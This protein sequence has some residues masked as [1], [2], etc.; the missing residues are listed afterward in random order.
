M[1]P[2][3]RALV[4]KMHGTHNA[5]VV[6]DERQPRFGSYVR[7]ARRV[8]ASD[9]LSADG[10]L[11]IGSPPDGD[12]SAL[13]SMRVINADGSEAE[14]CGNGVR[15]VARY[16]AERGAGEQFSIATAAGPIGIEILSRAPE[17]LVRV[18]MGVPE[19]LDEGTQRVEVAGRSWDLHRV[20]MGNPHAVIFVADV[21][22]V[23]VGR[24]GR[25][26]AR[27]PLFPEGVNVHV[28]RR[29]DAHTLQ[30][31]HYERGVGLTQACGTGAVAAVAA[32]LRE[33]IAETPVEVRVPGGKLVVEW[34]PGHSA[35]M[36]GPAENILEREIV[37]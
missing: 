1:V 2:Q 26:L 7:L 30:A 4:Q 19:F 18:D 15:C 17:F 34:S 31:R 25:E 9:Y 36:T 22:A 27:H 6:V 3:Q 33:G 23:D 13:A 14:M 5:F 24:L 28:V 35:K 37:L 16:L 32:A 10:L 11:V 21:D 29:L 8:C 20:S 12:A